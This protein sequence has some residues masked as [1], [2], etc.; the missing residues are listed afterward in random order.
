[1]NFPTSSAFNGPEK[2][3]SEAYGASIKELFDE[4]RKASEEQDATDRSVVKVA[5][6]DLETWYATI[7]AVVD[8]LPDYKLANNHMAKDEL[9]DVRDS[10]YRLLP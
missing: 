9:Y 8:H 2:A 1:M 10:I 4:A 3:V 7:N 6:S 5:L